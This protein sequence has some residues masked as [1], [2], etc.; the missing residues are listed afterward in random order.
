MCFEGSSKSNQ[1]FQIFSHLSTFAQEVLS[2]MLI[3]FLCTKWSYPLR[4]SSTFIL[5]H[6][7]FSLVLQN[8]NHISLYTSTCA[9]RVILSHYHGSSEGP[10][11]L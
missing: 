4:L 2:E 9:S 6:E 7:Y 3:A 1:P 8:I 5:F 10:G 11:V